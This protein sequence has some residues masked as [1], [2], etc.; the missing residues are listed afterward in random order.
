MMRRADRIRTE[1]KAPDA[2]RRRTVRVETASRA[3]A[4][5]R[6]IRCGVSMSDQKG[7]SSSKSVAAGGAG[8]LACWARGAACGWP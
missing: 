8:C 6:S 5:S 7:M 4:V 1:G 2:I 3:A